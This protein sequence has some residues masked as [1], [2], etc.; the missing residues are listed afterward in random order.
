[1][2]EWYEILIPIAALITACVAGITIYFLRRQLVMTESAYNLS[3]DAAAIDAFQK[4]QQNF[5]LNKSLVAVRSAIS[6]KGPV[7]RQDGG[8]IDYNDFAT[9]LE[10]VNQLL[11]FQNM[12]II[13]EIDLVNAFGAAAIEIERNPFVMKYI[14][15]QQKKYGDSILAGISEFAER[16]RKLRSH[17]DD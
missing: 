2:T 6:T 5:S 16:S 4:I 17:L 10:S 9:Y 11:Y 13:K 7:L 15:G 3:R 12:S 8:S 1:M 14:K